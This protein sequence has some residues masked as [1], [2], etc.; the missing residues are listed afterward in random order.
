[1]NFKAYINYL[2]DGRI[3]AGV[4]MDD[5]VL[6]VREAPSG[7]SHPIKGY[8]EIR[9]N[10]GVPRT[11]ESVQ[12]VVRAA[13]ASIGRPAD[14]SFHHV[15][16]SCGHFELLFRKGLPATPDDALAELQKYFGRII[17]IHEASNSRPPN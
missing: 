8:L 16:A 4:Y 10:E 17:T 2:Q 11:L 7:T 12:S 6:Y 15:D 13:Y 5:E 3:H 1:M 9:L 14:K